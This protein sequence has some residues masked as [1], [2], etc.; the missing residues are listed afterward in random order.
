LTVLVCVGLTFAID[1]FITAAKF[2]F[3]T[4]PSD[5]LRAIVKNKQKI[6]NHV[7]E[8]ESIYAKIRSK[9]VLEDISAE[10]HLEKR[11]DKLAALVLQKEH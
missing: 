10:K 2:N 5:F 7:G 11:R 1:L 4:S 9:Y 6:Q 3:L 8:F